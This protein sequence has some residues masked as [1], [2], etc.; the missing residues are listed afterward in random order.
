MKVL[1]MGRFS[2]RCYMKYSCSLLLFMMFL[3]S[4]P[5]MGFSAFYYNP[6]AVPAQVSPPLVKPLP[7]TPPLPKA[8]VQKVAPATSATPMVNKALQDMAQKPVLLPQKQALATPTVPLR[9]GFAVDTPAVPMAGS[10]I[11]VKGSLREQL[12]KYAKLHGYQVAWNH[13]NDL[14]ITNMTTFNQGSFFENIKKLFTTLEQTG[15]ID[16]TVTVFKGNKTI[17]VDKSKR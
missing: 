1:M 9:Q 12:N 14:V 3:T 8:P 15:R 16:M 7:K 2:K 6:Q 11:L 4:S 10:L 17:V 5:P 13:P